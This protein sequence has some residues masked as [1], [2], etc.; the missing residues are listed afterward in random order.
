MSHHNVSSSALKPLDVACYYGRI[1][2]RNSS[3]S[4]T[5]PLEDRRARNKAVKAKKQSNRKDWIVQ[6]KP[7]VWIADT[8]TGLTTYKY[9]ALRFHHKKLALD[10]VRM[11]KSR[12]MKPKIMRAI[13]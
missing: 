6:V 12:S 9:D 13:G 8:S 4:K 11:L 1:Q 7:N 5:S 10:A 2:Y 3:N